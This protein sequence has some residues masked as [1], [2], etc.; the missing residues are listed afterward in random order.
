MVREGASVV[1]DSMP[2]GERKKY[3][4]TS[5]LHRGIDLDIHQMAPERGGM[6]SKQRRRTAS[7]VKQKML[8]PKGPE[9][10]ITR[11]GKYAQA[12][13]VTGAQTIL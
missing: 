6:D 1:D 4:K 10:A 12:N 8:K 7:I 11:H 9:S 5:S 13:N 2:S 3:A